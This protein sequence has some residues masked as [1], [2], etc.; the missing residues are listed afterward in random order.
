MQ[1][2]EVLGGGGTPQFWHGAT[3]KFSP[4]KFKKKIE[5]T[6]CCD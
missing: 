2:I 1:R 6:F 3:K 4:Q 5:N